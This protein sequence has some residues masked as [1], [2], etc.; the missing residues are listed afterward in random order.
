MENCTIKNFG[1]FGLTLGGPTTSPAASAAISNTTISNIGGQAVFIDNR[2]SSELQAT[3]DHVHIYNSAGLMVQ[4]VGPTDV[5]VTDSVSANNST[6]YEVDTFQGGKAAIN[7]TLARSTAA[8]NIA[9]IY[10]NGATATLRVSQSTITGNKVGWDTVSGGVI[11]SY[12]DNIIDTNLAN[13]Q[14]ALPTV[15]KK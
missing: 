8:N 14:G 2:S 4:G 9:G 10:A 3:F 12:G 13:T 7:L 5:T 15:A 1:M 11:L 6:G